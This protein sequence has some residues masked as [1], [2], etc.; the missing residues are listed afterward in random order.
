MRDN[1]DMKTEKISVTMPANVIEAIRKLAESEKRS[2]SNMLSCLA[3]DALKN[4]AA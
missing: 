1:E 2:F 4:K 3:E